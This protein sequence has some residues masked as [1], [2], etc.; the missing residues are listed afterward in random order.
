VSKDLE[1]L[2]ED[3]SGLTVLEMS[4]LKEILEE[5]KAKLEGIGAKV[6]LKGL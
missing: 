4:K 6:T 3:L 5:I 1:Q 2:V